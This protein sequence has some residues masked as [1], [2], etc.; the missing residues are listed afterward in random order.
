MGAVD[1]RAIQMMLYQRL[2]QPSQNKFANVINPIVALLTAR[3]MTPAIVQQ[4]KQQLQNEYIKQVLEALK[5]GSGITRDQTAAALNTAKTG[6]AKREADIL[7][8]IPHEELVQGERAKRKIIASPGE[9][10]RAEQGKENIDLR[11]KGLEL[12]EARNKLDEQQKAFDREMSQLNYGQRERGQAATESYRQA[13]EKRKGEE[14]GSNYE[15]KVLGA[16]Q[17][18]RQYESTLARQN[19]NFEQRERAIR[20]RGGS[21]EAAAKKQELL[22]LRV[23]QAKL[24]V[25]AATSKAE[26]APLKKQWDAAVRMGMT[27]PSAD[28]AKFGK[29]NLEPLYKEM[30]GRS[31]AV[32]DNSW[33]EWFNM[34]NPFAEEET[35]SPPTAVA[36]PGQV[37]V[38]T[39]TAVPSVKTQTGTTLPMTD[40]QRAL[41]NY[42]LKKYG[43]AGQ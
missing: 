19:R 10:L 6:A 14:F 18:E 37:P 43:T 12:Q 32:P 15:F 21:P 26:N 39:E 33:G 24:N 17:K 20:A 36:T 5:V 4:Q 31:L 8:D 29:N 25:D 28:K 35:I 27:L 30:T 41:Q 38:T 3:Q 2:N 23:Q 13:T 1:P 11:K 40:A 34:F 9:T 16:E 42:K 22:D 7:G